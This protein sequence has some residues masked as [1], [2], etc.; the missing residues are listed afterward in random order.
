MCVQGYQQS[1]YYFEQFS[2]QF[3]Y[4]VT[5]K[6]PDVPETNVAFAFHNTQ[7]SFCTLQYRKHWH[8]LQFMGGFPKDSYQVQC[9]YACFSLFIAHGVNIHMEGDI[10]EKLQNAFIYNQM[11]YTDDT[12]PDTLL[13][14]VPKV[15][16]IFKENAFTQTEFLSSAS[17]E[18]F[19]KVMDGPF[20]GQLSTIIDSF[21][22]G[23]GSVS[24]HNHSMLTNF[25]LKCSQL[26]C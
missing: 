11:Y 16:T 20:R 7:S 22:A 9:P 24:T 12:S 23:H 5:D 14:K 25:S 3:R 18:R 26:H 13:Q 8:V 19:T 10:F 21:I 6:Y 4:F 2:N 17:I 1:P 15:M